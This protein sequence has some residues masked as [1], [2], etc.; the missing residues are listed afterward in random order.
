M[1]EDKMPEFLEL[2]E[3]WEGYSPIGRAKLNEAAISSALNLL[4]NTDR[5]PTHRWEYLMKEAI[6]TS[7][8][9]Y[10]F[11]GI[12]D[13]ELLARYTMVVPDWKSYV[14]VGSCKD[15]RQREMHKVQ[16][17]ETLLPEV[18]EKGEYLVAPMSDAHYHIQVY[19][20]GRQFDISWESLI[21]D[22]L[23]A[24]NDIP[25]RF[26]NACIY[27]EAYIATN[28][29]AV[30][31]GP[32]PLL[33]G[34]AIADVDGQVINNQG[35]LALTIANLEAT[36]GLMALQT[37]VLGR[38][39]GIQGKHL[40]VPPRQEFTARAI[41][42]SA[43]KQ[44]TEVGGGAG[45][46]VPTTNIIPQL[47]IQL[48]VNPLLP[49][50]DA[51]GN[52][53]GTWY[54]FADPADGVAIEYDYLRGHESPEVCMKSSDKVSVTGGAPVGPF[55]GDFASDNVFYRV[56][57]CGGAAPRDPRFAYAQVTA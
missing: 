51:S 42:T 32:N 35:A 49:V 13:R 48:H 52:R 3:G 8:F 27:T 5:L 22:D 24:F 19:K 14:K 15:F 4:M 47:G 53:N 55:E 1:K 57:L 7:D 45:V 43:L 56:R 54:V 31:A 41:L 20:R 10:L 18:K 40:V 12:L 11:G 23:G 30:A 36:L 46:P 38:P 26:S 2:I 6:T 21:N 28:Q 39:L 44:W 29:I 9:P 33:F 17:N 16:G 25:D 37:D 50:V 34:G